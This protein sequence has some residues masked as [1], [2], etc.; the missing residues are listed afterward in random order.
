MMPVYPLAPIR[1]D[2]TKV[3]KAEV[4]YRF[5]S[6]RLKKIHIKNLRTA[7]GFTEGSTSFDYALYFAVMTFSEMS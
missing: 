7:G 2:W 1:T 6:G 5:N 4:F 3:P